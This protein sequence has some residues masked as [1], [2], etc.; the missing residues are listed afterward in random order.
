M[1]RLDWF[2]PDVFGGTPVEQVLSANAYATQVEKIGAYAVTFTLSSASGFLSNGRVDISAMQASLQS[3]IRIS[4]TLSRQRG[5]EISHPPTV[6]IVDLHESG[7]PHIHGLFL[8]RTPDEVAVL[9]KVIAWWE[10]NH[11]STYVDPIRSL[12]HAA[13]V[14]CYLVSHRPWHDNPPQD[15]GLD[16]VGKHRSLSFLIS[17]D[18]PQVT[19]VC[20]AVEKNP[21]RVVAPPATVPLCISVNGAVVDFPRP[22]IKPV[23]LGKF[24]SDR[25]RAK[26]LSESS[27]SRLGVLGR[28]LAHAVAASD[29]FRARGLIDRFTAEGMVSAFYRVWSRGG[30]SRALDF[31]YSHFRTLDSRGV[32]RE[33]AALE[34]EGYDV[35]LV[36]QTSKGQRIIRDLDLG[37]MFGVCSLS[38][39]QLSRRSDEKYL[40]KMGISSCF[41]GVPA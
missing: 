28:F 31:L 7:L 23:S 27:S 16:A 13:S 32:W 1:E 24:D 40:R 6:C 4:R 21:A 17:R 11:G 8:C 3:Q 9:Q 22:L 33:I 19:G 39:E 37:N 30:A 12:A 35:G 38:P 26:I 10:R 25:M 41:S 5:Y 14:K 20:L 34:A 15:T 18:I 2:H 36:I 29:K